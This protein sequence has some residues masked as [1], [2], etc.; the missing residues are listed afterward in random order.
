[1]AN[2]YVDPHGNPLQTVT[3]AGVVLYV[4]PLIAFFAFAQ[5]FIVRGIVTT[6]IKG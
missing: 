1:M 6:G 3:M 4:L 2:A 5:R